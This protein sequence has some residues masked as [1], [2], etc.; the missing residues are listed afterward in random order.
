VRAAGGAGERSSVAL[1]ADPSVIERQLL[2]S[3]NSSR[4]LRW[5]AQRKDT[6]S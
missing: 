5:C 4:R 3:P 2:R 1:I 6:P